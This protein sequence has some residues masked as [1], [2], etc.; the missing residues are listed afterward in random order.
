M[1]NNHNNS[2]FNNHQHI[3]YGIHDE[4]IMVSM[5]HHGTMIL[6]KKNWITHNSMV[7]ICWI[8]VLSWLFFQRLYT[9]FLQQ[10]FILRVTPWCPFDVHLSFSRVSVNA[11]PMTD[12]TMDGLQVNAR[13]VALGEDDRVTVCAS[14]RP[15]L[16]WYVHMSYEY[17]DKCKHRNGYV[18]LSLSICDIVWCV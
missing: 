8:M 3:D 17:K 14:Q 18:P 11:R 13:V 6:K 10:S 9:A 1:D 16:E 12:N 2:F 4:Y 7:S 15:L 5:V